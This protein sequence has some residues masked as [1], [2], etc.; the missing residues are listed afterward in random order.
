MGTFHNQPEFAT[1]GSITTIP[2]YNLTDVSKS[3]IY[4]GTGGNLAIIP[5]D[6]TSVND[7][8]V[9]MNLSAGTF[10]PVIAN[11]ILPIPLAGGAYRIIKDGTDIFTNSVDGESFETDSGYVA[12][13]YSTTCQVKDASNS[14]ANIGN[15][16]K[17]DIT[18]VGTSITKFVIKEA[19]FDIANGD[20]FNVAANVLGT[21][22][23]FD[24][25]VTNAD[26]SASQNGTTA[27]GTINNVAN[28]IATFK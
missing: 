14:D 3:A 1:E 25:A 6:K 27:L 16:I 10:A 13:T 21:H 5:G 9:F 8:V 22:S 19:F 28:S 17:V 2:N 24:V 23:A 12:G 20:K 7:V 11:F 15:P 26:T 18:V 4:I